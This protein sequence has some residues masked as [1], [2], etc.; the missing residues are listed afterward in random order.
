MTENAVSP[1]MP[2]LAIGDLEDPGSAALRAELAGEPV[3]VLVVRRGERIDA[4][5]NICP[6][7]ALPL[8]FQP[9]RFLDESGAYILC[10]NH[11]ALFRIDDGECV[12]GPCPGA[13]LRRAHVDVH[14]GI[15]TI[16]GLADLM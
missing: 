14:Q 3:E 6:H 7:V 2:G 11:G 16:T 5:V 10:A 9:G 13:R 1:P 4:Y 12:A 15:I 8:D